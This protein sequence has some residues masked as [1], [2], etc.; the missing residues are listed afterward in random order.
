M[1]SRITIH[2]ASK[3]EATRLKHRLYSLRSAMQAEGH[4]DAPAAYRTTIRQRCVDGNHMLIGQPVDSE[5]DS[6]LAEAG[7]GDP[8]APTLDESLIEISPEEYTASPPKK[9]NP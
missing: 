2:C 8:Q 9:I 4:E 3:Q 6:I 1:A 5:F 7:I